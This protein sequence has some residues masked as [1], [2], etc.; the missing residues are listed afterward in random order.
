MSCCRIRNEPERLAL[1]KM[2]LDI[3]QQFLMLKM[4]IQKQ[5]LQYQQQSQDQEVKAKLNTRFLSIQ[6]MWRSGR[7]SWTRNR[8]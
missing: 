6:L 1:V 7:N 8:L 3:W 4:K 2:S 5:A